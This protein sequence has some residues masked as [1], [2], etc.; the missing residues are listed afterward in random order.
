MPGVQTTRREWV[1]DHASCD[2][3]ARRT[4]LSGLRC[5]DH[6]IVRTWRKREHTHSMLLIL[7]AEGL[8]PWGLPVLAIF[9]P[10]GL[11]LLLSLEP[12]CCYWLAVGVPGSV[13]PVCLTKGYPI[14]R[15]H[16]IFVLELPFVVDFRMVSCL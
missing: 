15:L 13:L 16:G 2:R 9:G 6:L 10:P 1:S 4:I 5:N 11:L 3:L 14:G 12:I 8:T 7:M